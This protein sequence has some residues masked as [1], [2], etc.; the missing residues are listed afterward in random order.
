MTG[1]KSL[2]LLMT[3]IAMMI[4][5]IAPT[6]IAECIANGKKCQSDGSLGSCCSNFCLQK[7]GQKT[8]KCS[9]K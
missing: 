4:M 8:G 7:K 5:L 3:I 2:G 9:K 1:F 6:A